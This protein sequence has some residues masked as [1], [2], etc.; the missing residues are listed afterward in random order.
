MTYSGS[1]MVVIGSN[2]PTTRASQGACPREAPA[3]LARTPQL[4]AIG[5]LGGLLSGL[6]G[7]GG[8]VIMVP[9]LALWANQDQRTAHALSLG[10]I[11]PIGAAGIL[12]YGAAGEVRPLAALG[13]LAGSVIG[14][15][16]GAGLLA[17]TP[18]RPLKAVFG[19]FLVAVAILMALTS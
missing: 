10:A 6:L 19:A 7:V 12:A 9:L 18:D 11:V 17:R 2:R 3:P 16:Y 13:L 4:L 5:C 1:E 15:R 14:A 8:G